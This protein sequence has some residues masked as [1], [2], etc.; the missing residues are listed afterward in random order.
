MEV[1]SIIN[2]PVTIQYEKMAEEKGQKKEKP[3]GGKKQEVVN[4][5]IKKQQQSEQK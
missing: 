4:S 1:G 2:G 5:E 3:K